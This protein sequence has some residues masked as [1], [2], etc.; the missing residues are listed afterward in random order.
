MGI[1]LG[2]RPRRARPAFLA[3]LGWLSFRARPRKPKRASD[4]HQYSPD[5]PI[6][7]IFWLSLLWRDPRGASFMDKAPRRRDCAAFG[8]AARTPRPLNTLE[9]CRDA[10][11]RLLLLHRRWAKMHTGSRGRNTGS[12][13]IHVNI[14]ILSQNFASVGG[15][16]LA[17]GPQAVFKPQAPPSTLK[18]TTRTPAPPITMLR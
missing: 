8:D 16:N 2:G 14:F 12:P 9:P 10:P 6:G 3:F 4:N 15:Q 1:V 17:R 11:R 5:W 7:G 18:P 13:T